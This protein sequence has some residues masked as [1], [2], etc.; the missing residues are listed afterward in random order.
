MRLRWSDVR[1]I[2]GRLA[3]D[4]RRTD[5]AVGNGEVVLMKSDPADEIAAIRLSKSARW[6]CLRPASL[7]R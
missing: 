4:I 3:C 6:R 7:Q 1:S 5:V 2:R